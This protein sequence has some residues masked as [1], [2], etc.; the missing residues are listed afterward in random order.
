MI[1]NLLVLILVVA[2]ALIT[3]VA[4]LILI[5]ILP[6]YR[7]TPVKVQ[8]F[9]A[10]NIPIGHPKWVLPMQY[11]GFVIIF[12]ALEP[13]FVLILLLSAVPTADVY[14]FTLIALALFI[15]ALYAGF[16]YSLDIAGLKR[17]GK[18]G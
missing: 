4:V 2:V 1:E 9:E 18:D 11:L 13:V 8:R 5:K 17:G 6:K 7:M 14:A 15:P 12:L 16:N 3:D 10:G